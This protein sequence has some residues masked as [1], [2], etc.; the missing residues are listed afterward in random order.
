MADHRDDL[1]LLIH[2]VFH[3]PTALVMGEEEGVQGGGE[4]IH[5]V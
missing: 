2:D 1:E 3:D 5:R 4:A